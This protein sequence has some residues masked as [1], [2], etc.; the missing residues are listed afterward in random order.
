[1]TKV[2]HKQLRYMPLIPRVKRLFLSRKTPMHIRWQKD[3]TDRQDGLMVHP[4]DGDAWKTLDNFDPDFASDARN[5]R[6]GLATDGFTPFNMRRSTMRSNIMRR[7][8]TMRMSNMRRCST[9]H[10]TR[11]RNSTSHG[12]SGITRESRNKCGTSGANRPN[13]LSTRWMMA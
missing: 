6:I 5:V 12:T 11:P 1:V 8:S 3:C 2:A 9:R 4:S 7:S 13:R 10:G